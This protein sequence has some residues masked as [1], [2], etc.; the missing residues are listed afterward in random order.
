M[1]FRFGF[2]DECSLGDDLLPYLQ[3]VEN[4]DD[5]VAF[6]THFHRACFELITVPAHK[7]Q[8]T[9]RAVLNRAVLTTSVAAAYTMRFRKTLSGFGTV[10]RS[11]IPGR[12]RTP[13]DR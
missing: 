3:T 7:D 5:F 10:T 12:V 13:R 6:F 4:R 9:G 8:G 1:P 2:E 11:R